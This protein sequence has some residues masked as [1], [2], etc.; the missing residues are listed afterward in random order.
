MR[1]AIV[2]L[3]SLGDVV[4][5]L[6][7][8]RALHDDPRVSRL[9]WIVEER[10]Q[11]LLVDNPAVDEVIV[12][13]TRRW[14]RQLRTARGARSV[15]REFRA[16]RERLRDLH[17]DVAVEVQGF[18]KSTLFT[19][20]TRAPIRIG[21]GWRHVRDRF[22]SAFTTHWVTPPP[23]AAHIVEQNMA[24]LDPLGVEDRRIAFPLPVAPAAEALAAQRLRALGIAEHRFLAML[25]ATRGPAKQWPAGCY[26]EAARQLA[27]K[28]GM[29]VLLLGGPG[30]EPLLRTVATGLEASSVLALAPEPIAELTAYLRRARVVLGNDTGPLHLAAAVGVPAVGLYGPTR[31]ERNG[32]YGAAS[33]FIQSPTRR[34]ED[35]DVDT[36]VRAVMD[37]LETPPPA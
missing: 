36:V 7:L 16:L 26:R 37:R 21:F 6:P 9:A 18:L 2:R 22:S 14:R 12:A 33:R 8:A 11:A 35:I 34:V 28:A 31:G 15:A 29:S 30:E 1:V 3:T 10:E 24:L 19:V 5:T 23:A 32:P 4:H 27:E 20:L 17:L 25:P 13:P